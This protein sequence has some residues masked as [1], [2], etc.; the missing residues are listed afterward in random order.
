MLRDFI[1]DLAHGAR[2]LRR[3]PGVTAVVVTTLAITIGAIVTVFSIVDAW[4]FRPLNFPRPEQLVIAFAARP[5]TPSEPAVWLPYRAYLGWK[6]RSRSYTSLSAAFVRD[7]T[8][9]SGADAQT[10]LGL[11]VTPEFFETYGVAPLLGRTLS[12]QDVNG[13]R[14]VVL[15][16]GIWQ[17]RFGG[18][19]DVVGKPIT[20]SGVPHEVVGVMP[21][22][23]ETRLLDMRFEFWTPFLR[24]QAEYQPGG[25][26]PVALV[27]RLRD[28][29]TIGA[30][31]AEAVQLTRELEAAY[32]RNFNAYV[33]NVTSLQGDNSRNVRATLLTISA[34]AAALLLIAAMNVGTLLLGRGLTR[35]REAAIRA[36]I[37]SGRGRLAR[38]FLTESLLIASLGAIAGV[39]L[40]VLGTRLF[41]AWD[42]LGVLPANAIRFDL[43]VVTAAGIALAVTTIVCGL[44]PALR[45][46]QADPYDALRSGD[47][48]GV[49]APTQRAQLVMLGTQV[50]A[51]WCCWR[52]RRS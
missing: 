3:Q 39:A 13:P 24:E 40:A 52:R 12:Q 37:G 8:V 32:P 42:P 23:F 26:G 30:A 25:I 41:I 31:R 9:T 17:R 49:A 33:A 28:G 22:D 14:A 35:R 47:R 51:C 34:A 45:V 16:D 21:R 10:V 50:C 27:A 36:A 4:L 43:R 44:I 1:R 5:E 38:Q 18:S 48:S 11:S 6:E 15:G 2:L 29:V 20:M 19:R 7:V 46:S